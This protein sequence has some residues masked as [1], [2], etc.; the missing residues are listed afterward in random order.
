MRSAQGGSPLPS[1]SCSGCT[2]GAPTGPPTSSSTTP[3]PPRTSRRSRS[4]PPSAISTASTGGG[5]SARGCTA[6]SSTAPSTTPAPG[7]C[8][9]RPSSSP[10]LAAP[11]AAAGRPPEEALLAAIA[12][13]PP[14]QR[15]VIV[16]RHLLEYT[17]GEIATMLELPRGT[18]NSRLR[19]GLD[20]MREVLVKPELERIEIPGAAEAEERAAARR[21]ARVRR[22]AARCP[23]AGRAGRSWPSR[24]PS[25]SSPPCSA[26][27]AGPS[28]STSAVPSGSKARSRRSSRC[29]RRGACSSL[30][31]RR[32]DRAA[33]GSRRLLGPYEE[34]S[35]SPFGRY[36]VATRP[37]ELVD[38]R[39]RGQRALD[40]RAPRRPVPALERQRHR[41]ADRIPERRPPPRR[42]R[43]RHGRPRPAAHPPPAS[44]PHGAAAPGSCS[45]TPTRGRRVE[46]LL[47]A[48]GGK[49]WKRPVPARRDR[50]SARATARRLLVL[51]PGASG[52]S[53]RIAAR[54]SA[55]AA[56]DVAAVAYRPG[57]QDFAELH[58]SAAREPRHARREG[59]VQLRRRASRPDVVAGRPL[60]SRRLAGLGPVGVHPCRR[61]RI[62]AVS[63]VSAQFHSQSFPR[64][65][66]WCCGVGSRHARARRHGPRRARLDGAA[67]GACRSRGSARGRGAALLCF[68]VFDWSPG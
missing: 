65:E 48:K 54:R 45:P 17:P 53:T 52:S 66:G 37:N 41:H 34:A 62:V 55:E 35:W 24:S 15:A 11:A 61:T 25:R 59:A 50:S 9:P 67:R 5:R 13:L 64:V 26:R 36:V 60:A 1:R 21:D 68:Y 2:G 12:R 18:V 14:E 23:A 51:S 27:R 33:D 58:G 39:C 7:R 8:G 63:N 31:R 44:P 32:L 3:R 57:A 49:L 4:S 42:R 16:L 56:P 20:A 47:L 30:R 46:A 28:S 19:R 29:P 43:R 6:S 38:A 22:A 10:A 40:A